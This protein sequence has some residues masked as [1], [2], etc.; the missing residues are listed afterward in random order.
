M[1]GATVRVV[2]PGPNA[3]IQDLGRPGWFSVGVGVAGAADTVSLRLANR[4]VGNDDGAAG[5]ECVLGGLH[6]VA[7]A[8][9]TLAV[10][11]AP[12]P[13]TVDGKAAAH[14][15]TLHLAARQELALGFA[16]AGMRVYVGVRGGLAVEPVLDSR[17]RDTLA[18]LG[19]EPLHAGD[20][21]PVGPEPNR[22]QA[23]DAAS[24]SP[25][26]KGPVTVRVGLGPRDDWFTRPADL[27][28]G[29]WVA[30]DRLDRVGIRLDR[31]AGAPALT[32]RTQ[33]ELPTEGMPLGAIQVPPSGEPVVFLA[34]H[35]ITG[36]YPVIGVVLGEDV[37]ALAQVR[38]GQQVVFRPND[39]S[40]ASPT[41]RI[42][43]AE[44][45]AMSPL[46]L[47]GNPNPGDVAAILAALAL[48]PLD[49]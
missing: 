32:R 6:L 35:P 14:S 49:R 38:P 4:L 24:A 18:G 25:V 47:R 45:N 42:T 29:H 27:F 2:A 20:E 39:A 34:D 23:P 22:P 33:D 17:S 36:G 19:P 8:A 10:T 48:A 46:R 30:S 11:G 15:S 31:P 21:L 37:P 40:A 28:A 13:V 41:R 1:A 7:L 26:T 5:I 44:L 9:V 12:A 43:F 16:P 3:T